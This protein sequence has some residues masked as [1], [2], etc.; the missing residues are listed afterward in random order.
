[1]VQNRDFMFSGHLSNISIG[2]AYEAVVEKYV[3][4]I[5]GFHS[6]TN[7]DFTSKFNNKSKSSF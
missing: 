1:M 6:F 7:S 3:K 4:A 5:F 2:K